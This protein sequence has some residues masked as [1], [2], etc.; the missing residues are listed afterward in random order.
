M[1]WRKYHQNKSVKEGK[2]GP[3]YPIGRGVIVRQDVDGKW[4]LFIDKGGKRKNHTFGTG[5]DNLAEAIRKAEQ[6]SEKLDSIVPVQP[7][8]PV[9]SGAPGFID[10]A[11]K[12][13]EINAGRWKLGTYE[14]YE[15]I[16]RLHVSTYEGF[17]NVK[18]DKID[19]L[20]VRDFLLYIRGQKKSQK[21]VELVHAVISGIFSSLIEDQLVVSNPAHN[22]LKKILSKKRQRN[23]KKPDPFT[24]EERGIFLEKADQLCD[25]TQLLLIKVM[26]FAGFRLGETLAMRAE[27]LDFTK[28]T[29]RITESYKGKKF[30]VPKSGESRSVDL[31]GFLMDELKDYCLYLKK[32]SLKDGKGGQIDLLFLDRA[33]DDGFPYS[34]RKI[35]SLVKGVCKAAGL[36]ARSPHQTRHTYATIMLM[37]HLSPAYVQRQ[38]GHSSIQMTV[39]IYGHWIPGEGRQGLEDALCPVP[40]GGGNRIYFRILKKMKPV[41]N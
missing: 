38:L 4:I 37:A 25:G 20:M 15:T 30:G 10:Y 27:H 3:I 14:R 5:R 2:H 31:P 32:E 41:T 29:Y 8:E 12:W 40:N 17:A 19:R 9:N 35:Q 11:W 33:E 24:M 36:R 34:Q 16:M 28:M 6:I 26:L 13:L 22:V 21:T 1:P 23:R 18:V 7:S 39:D